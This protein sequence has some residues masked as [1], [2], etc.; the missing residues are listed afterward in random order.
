[1]ADQAE[2][3]IV[4]FHLPVLLTEVLGQLGVRPG[5]VYVDGTVG[6]G[7]HALAF[8]RASAPLGSVC[9]IDLD[10][11]SLV[12]TE[13]RLAPFGV[14]FTPILGS[15][16]E[17]VSLVQGMLGSEAR[18]DGVLL[19][20][21][22]SSRQVDG[23]GFGFSFQQDE[24]L[25]MRFNP[26]ADIPTAADIVNTWS[27]EG[28]VAVLREYGEEPRAG[29]I[30]SAI[31][32]QRPISS[33]VQL[34]SVV[35]GAAG[36][37]SGRTHPA[38]RTFQALRIAVNDELNTLTTGLQAAVDLLAPSGRLAVISYHS[39]EDRRVKTFLAREAHQP[40]VSLVNRR[41]IRP[42]AGEIAENPRSRSARMR[43]AQRLAE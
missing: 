1:M 13:Q 17:M 42:S 33:T 15:Y 7:G 43:V 35:A 34:A 24:P 8:L 9:G 26:E 41:I 18:A 12:R 36:R 6:D 16:A 10:P 5:G 21:G 25:D 11:R 14:Q 4:P 39:L 2:G 27:R 32:R 20:L 23:S 30:A 31:V 29:A 40:R 22:I 3:V 28:L 19:D 38:T 37:Q